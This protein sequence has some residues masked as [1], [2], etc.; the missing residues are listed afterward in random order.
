M[1]ALPCVAPAPYCGIQG[2]PRERCGC[3]GG[4]R[5][6]RYV[7]PAQINPAT[8]RVPA[9]VSAS[10]RC[11]SAGACPAGGRRPRRCPQS[12]AAPGGYVPTQPVQRGHGG[13]DLDAF[14]LHQAQGA[15]DHG[16][17]GRLGQVV[18]GA[19]LDRLDRRGHA[20]VAGDQQDP[21]VGAQRAKG[22]DQG[23]AGVLAQA[24][25]HQGEGRPDLRPRA[26]PRRCRWRCG[27][28]GP[29]ATG[30]VARCA[31]T[32]RRR[33]SAGQGR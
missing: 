31:H 9:P 1:V 14:R 17:G 15:Q 21:H 5:V 22:T 19:A 6:R 24:Q 16:G 2:F 29:G 3:R 18:V 20:G 28:P 33:R 23:Q 27:F 25:V 26:A 30:C 32:A 4:G 7:A 12:R 10:L 8:L 11:R 13:L